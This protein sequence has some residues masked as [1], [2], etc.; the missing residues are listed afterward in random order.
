MEAAAT[1]AAQATVK[2]N[3]PLRMMSVFFVVAGQRSSYLAMIAVLHATQAAHVRAMNRPRATSTQN[4]DLF[5]RRGPLNI[6]VDLTQTTRSTLQQN[7]RSP[8][9]VIVMSDAICPLTRSLGR[10]VAA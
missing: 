5:D 7:N 9:T 2:R 6:A 10:L 4:G 1:A 3:I 8:V